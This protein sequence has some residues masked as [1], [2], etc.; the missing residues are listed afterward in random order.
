MAAVIDTSP[1]RSRRIIGS[2]T[3]PRFTNVVI[4]GGVTPVIGLRVGGSVTRGGWKRAGELPISN[5]TLDATLVTMEA[6]YS[7]R[8]SK[9]IGEWTRD[10]LDTT[11]G[12]SV[13]TG[14][15]IQA[16]QVLT[17]T[18]L[19][20]GARRTHRR[21]RAGPAPRAVVEAFAG[22][23]EVLGFRLTPDVTFRVGHRA[24]RPFGADGLR[25]PG[26]RV[27]RL[28][29]P[30]VLDAVGWSSGLRWEFGLSVVFGRVGR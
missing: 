6:D 12:R 17:P 20:G 10:A 27:D 19:P 24:R 1:L 26:R 15:Y 5:R 28:G 21:A 9:V 16:Q 8:Y 18:V 22:T 2:N 25:E 4:G 11:T 23:E 29:A 7:F 3:T 14:W 30:L 13:A